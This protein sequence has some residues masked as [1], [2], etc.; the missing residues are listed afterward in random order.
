MGILPC[1]DVAGPV[2][3]RRVVAGAEWWYKRTTAPQS[4][5]E[6]TAMMSGRLFVRRPVPHHRRYRLDGVRRQYEARH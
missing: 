2:Q 6:I 1:Q 3:T 4:V 5:T